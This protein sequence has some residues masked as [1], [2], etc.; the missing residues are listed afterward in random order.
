ML[1]LN[2][3]HDQSERFTTEPEAWS[4][5]HVL[6]A[7][8]S[9]LEGTKAEVTEVKVDQSDTEETSVI[10]LRGVELNEI[11]DTI[12]SLA[13]SLLQDCIAVYCTET[14]SG[15]LAGRYGDVWGPFNM[16]YFLV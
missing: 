7:V 12:D 15:T 10:Y 8:H 2:I 13:E 4:A 1:I 5:V 9:A 14:D 11:L 6:K 16:D 3:G